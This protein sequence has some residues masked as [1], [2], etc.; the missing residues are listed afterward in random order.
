MK[1]IYFSNVKKADLNYNLNLWRRER[2]METSLKI[3]DLKHGGR[4]WNIERIFFIHRHQHRDDN[5]VKSSSKKSLFGYLPSY[6]L[7]MPLENCSKKIKI[8]KKLNRISMTEW[9]LSDF[10]GR[11]RKNLVKEKINCHHE[12]FKFA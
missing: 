8:A 3:N 10:F 12:E 7:F 5:Q 2:E 9:F 6:H 4:W 1:N 11:K